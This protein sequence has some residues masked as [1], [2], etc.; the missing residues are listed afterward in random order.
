MDPEPTAEVPL[1]DRSPWR[2]VVV[3]SVLSSVLT[4]GA[5]VLALYVLAPWDGEAPAGVAAT[6]TEP[7]PYTGDPHPEFGPFVFK[8]GKDY[9]CTVK[10]GQN[11]KLAAGYSRTDSE[12]LEKN[13]SRWAVVEAQCLL[14]HHG[15]DPGVADGSFG[16]NTLRAV[17]RVQ[18]R[19]K[20]A[21]DGMVGPD[22][23]K[24]LRS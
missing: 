2:A 24:V 22:T 18:T 7:T 6:A 9:P 5:V 14:K 4:A 21:V 12:H 3:S 17:Q 20:V 8:P 16:N 15:L 19:G 11:G 1:R 23:W 13:A 10:R